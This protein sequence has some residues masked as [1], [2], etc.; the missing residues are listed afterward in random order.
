MKFDKILITIAIIIGMFF[1]YYYG[2]ERI[3]ASTYF[4]DYLQMQ[5][6]EEENIESKELFKDWKRGGYNMK[7]IYSD[8]KDYTYYYHYF[9]TTK[10]RNEERKFH[11]VDFYVVKDGC[12]LD[13]PYPSER[14]KQAP[15]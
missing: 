10:G 3:L 1:L 9:L 13:E 14:K 6:V 12:V 8:K 15:D 2:I 5:G 4:D 7:V 11:V